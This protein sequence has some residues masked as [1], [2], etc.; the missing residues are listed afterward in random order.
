MVARGACKL[1]K[2]VSEPFKIS[3]GFLLVMCLDIASCRLTIGQEHM[4]RESRC[5]GYQRIDQHSFY[6]RD[7]S[8]PPTGHDL[9]LRRRPSSAVRDRQR[10]LT[11][12][13]SPVRPLHCS[14][15]VVKGALNPF[16]P[17]IWWL[18]HPVPFL[19]VVYLLS[20]S[21]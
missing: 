4:A 14:V 7:A 18:F 6:K 16:L 9:P 19:T 21:P 3:A 12:A 5:Q 10:G 17:A 2:T 8:G 20:Y 15:F 1:S 13:A 11:P